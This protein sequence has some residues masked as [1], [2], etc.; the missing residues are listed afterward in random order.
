[1]RKVREIARL[2]LLL[3]LFGRATSRSDYLGHIRAAELAWPLRPTS[4]ATKHSSGASSRRRLRWPPR[5]TYCW[6]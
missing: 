1:M 5:G 6:R 2:Y 4:T 3:K